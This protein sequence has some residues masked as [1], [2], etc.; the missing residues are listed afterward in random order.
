MT[1]YVPLTPS[2][3]IAG[4]PVPFETFRAVIDNPTAIAEGASGAP[5]VQIPGAVA[6]S[7]TDTTKVLKPDGSGGTVWGAPF[8]TLWSNT[9]ASGSVVLPSISSGLWEF[10][11]FAE[12]SG[13]GGTSA[14]FSGLL[15]AT[16]D[17]IRQLQGVYISPPLTSP[18]YQIGV[19][20][21]AL[22]TTPITLS[23]NTGSNVLSV[24]GSS[25]AIAG[26]RATLV[27]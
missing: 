19:T 14:V 15:D 3:F 6:T 2:S 27:G 1:A 16:N 22:G 11:G 23:W 21:I 10:S 9:I 20:T 12:D 4:T 26:L 17:V 7:E 25:L 18:F 24:S 13:G 8:S 5:R